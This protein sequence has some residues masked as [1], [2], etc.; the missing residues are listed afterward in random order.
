[1]N[2]MKR[3]LLGV[4]AFTIMSAPLYADAGKVAKVKAKSECCSKDCCNENCTNSKT[5]YANKR[6]L[7]VLK[8]GGCTCC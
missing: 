3:L 5:V 2:F 7:V 8:G 4:I 1:M 6:G